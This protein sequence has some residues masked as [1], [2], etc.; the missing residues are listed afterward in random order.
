MQF[1]LEPNHKGYA[2]KNKWHAPFC[3]QAFDVVVIETIVET[4]T[5]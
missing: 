3:N 2:T 1:V 5:P 4:C